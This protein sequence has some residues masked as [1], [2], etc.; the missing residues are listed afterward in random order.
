MENKEL[1]SNNIIPFVDY[2][3]SGELIAGVDIEDRKIYYSSKYETEE[4]VKLW[5]ESQEISNYRNIAV[6]FGIADGRYVKALRKINKDMLILVYEPSIE[7]MN[8][9]DENHMMDEIK[10]DTST[11]MTVGEENLMM[12]YQILGNTIDYDNYKLVKFYV[13]PNYENVYDEELISLKKIVEEAMQTA[14]FNRNT[15]LLLKDEINVNISHNIMDFIEQYSC[16]NLIEA[17]QTTDMN[18]IPAIIVAAGPSL[19]KNINELK[20]AKGKAFIIAVDTALNALA[21]ADIIPDIAVTID[22]HKPVVLFTNEKMVNV[23]MV[24]ALSSN[25]KIL[26]VHKGKRI[27]QG[28]TDSLLDIFNDKYNVQNVPLETGG[29]VACNA[30]SLARHLGFKTIIFIGQDLAYPNDK[31]HS[32]YSY[33]KDKNNTI[34]ENGKKYF[35]VEDIYGGQVKTEYNMNMYRLWFEKAIKNNEHIRHIDATEGGAKINGTEIMTLKEALAET[36]TSEKMVDFGNIIDNM[37]T[38][39]NSEQKKELYNYIA[40]FEDEVKAIKDR[41]KEGKKLYEKL[42]EYNRKQNYSGKGFKKVFDQITE[43]NDWF[44]N[45]KEAIYL[46]MY[47]AENDY[48]VRESIYEEKDNTYDEIKLVIDSGFKMI[49]SLTESTDKLLEDMKESIQ[50]SKERSII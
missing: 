32:E 46:S 31:E 2:N 24:I 42:D 30:H 41:L 25:Y 20:N 7:L 26:D 43:F 6:V 47:S 14:V 45:D 8:L 21:K 4:L 13:S 35:F 19:D 33:G 16:K 38:C 18:N 28:A 50:I 44:T 29:S 48:E 17:M 15:V 1:N 37:P 10:D 23:P 36:C 3:V 40:N 34:T 49:N 22:P 5:S 11:I 39:Y 12:V 9:L 27:Y